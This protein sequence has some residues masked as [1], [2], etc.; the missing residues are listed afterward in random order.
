MGEDCPHILT[1]KG[2][3][4]ICHLWK[5]GSMQPAEA[6]WGPLQGWAPHPEFRHSL[7]FGP[8]GGSLFVWARQ[9]AGRRAA[10]DEWQE[11]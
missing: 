8:G 7:G 2:P 1:S 9:E 11:R 5:A 6:G 4:G 10:G 3:G